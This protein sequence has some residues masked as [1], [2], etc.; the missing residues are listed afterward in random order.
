MFRWIAAHKDC[1]GNEKA[2]EQAKL[3][4]SGTHDSPA[5]ELPQ[6]L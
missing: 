2:D 1:I 6:M 3:A 5:V 4:S